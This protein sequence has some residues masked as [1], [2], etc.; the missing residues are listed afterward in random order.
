[1]PNTFIKIATVTVGSSGAANI[2]FTNIPQTFTDLKLVF[3][4]RIITGSQANIWYKFN[5]STSSLSWRGLYGTGS[6][7]GSNNGTTV[8]LLAGVTTAANDTASVFASGEIYIPNYTSSN[9]KSSA[10]DNVGENN[11]TASTVYLVANLWSNTA[12]IN[13]ITLY[14]DYNFAQYSEATLYGITKA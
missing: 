14:S 6:A 2:D 1:M 10:V 7:A 12:A 9:N 8:G 11:A 13:Q 5:N 4:T 3:S